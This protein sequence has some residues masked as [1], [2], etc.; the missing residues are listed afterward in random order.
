M[1]AAGESGGVAN[2]ENPTDLVGGGIARDLTPFVGLVEASLES[3]WRFDLA[4]SGP[5][6]FGPESKMT[7]LFMLPSSG[8]CNLGSPP[9]EAGTT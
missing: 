2:A 4:G 3:N 9:G 6:T 1:E 8:H 7:G 5:T